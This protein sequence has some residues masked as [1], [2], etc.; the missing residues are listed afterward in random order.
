MAHT[1]SARKRM[2][3]NVKRNLKNRAEKGVIKA[4]VKRVLAAIEA[5]DKAAAEKELQTATKL[6]D[7]AGD[8]HVVHKNFSARKKSA[9]ARKINAI[10]A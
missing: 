2:R 4:Q 1:R 9:L 8:K 3:Q 6:L 10:T 5:K 7:R